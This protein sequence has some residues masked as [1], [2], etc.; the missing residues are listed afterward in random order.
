MRAVARLAAVFV[1]T[2]LLF[3]SI[4]FAQATISGLVRDTSGA[5]LPGVTV[6]AASPVLIEKVRTAVTDGNGRYQ[7][8][9]LRPG[10]YSVTVSLAGFNTVKRD[11]L[12]VT[13]SSIVTVDVELR[14]GSLEE[15][16]TVTGESPVVDTQSLTTQRVINADT[17]DALPS[18]RNYFGVARMVPGT[19][20]GGNDVGGSLIQDVGQGVTV[21]GSRQVDQRITINGI[22]TMTLQAGGGIGG[23][24]PDM[25]SAA[26]VTVDTSALG[27]DLPTGGLRVNFVPKDGGN[28]FSNSA[29]FSFTNESLQGDNFSDELRAQG[30]TT[31]NKILHAVD[32]NESFGGPMKRDKVWFWASFRVNDV[33][34]EAPV[35]VNKNAF[36]PNAWL[37]DPD[38]AQAGVNRGE[39]YNNSVRVTWQANAKNKIAGT[40]K[41]D[42][43]CNCP[44]Q[45]SATLAPEAARDRRFPRLRQE[46]A[47]WT[48]PVTNKLLF[49][50]VGMHLYERWG[51][52]HLRSS[53]GSITEEQEAIQPQMISVTEQSS[54]LVY[55]GRGP[56]Y[57]NTAVPSLSLRAAAAYVTGSHAFKVGWNH[58]SGYLDE[59]L[60]MLND[61][62]TY[63]FNTVGGVTTPNLVTLRGNYHA[64]TNLDGDMGLY[65]QDRW[66]M[67]RLTVAGAIRFDWFRTSFPDQTLGP[68]PMAP[69]R[70][71]TFP[72]ADNINWKDLTYRSGLSYDLFGTGKTAV[73]FSFNKYLLG[74]TLNALGRDP[75]P[76]IVAGNVQPTRAW[77]DLM[78]PV[79]DPRRGNFV[80]DCDLTTR[81][82]G[83]NGE[84]GAL[85]N[86][87]FGSAVPTEQF[88]PDL[89]S[90]FNHR[91]TNWET[92]VSV[93]HELMPRVG[94]DVGYFR[95]SW[96]NFRV[97]DNTLL[98]P[99]D[100][101][102]Y[103][104]VNP[105]DPRLGEDS[106]ATVRG[107]VD[108][109]PSK[110]GQV[111]NYNTLSTK[112]G[113]QSE[114]WQGVDVT[115]N[116]R[117]Q[118]GL[119]LQGGFS[120]GS[121]HEN[122]C[123][124]LTALPEMRNLA[125]VGNA[126]RPAFQRALQHCDRQSPY[127]T[128]AKLFG[129]YLVPKLDVQVSG[130][131]RSV[132][133]QIQG[134]GVNENFANVLLVATTPFLASNSNLGRP[135]SGNAPNSTVEILA[136][137]EHYLDRRNELDFR[138]GKL[139]R[140]NR[141]RLVLS[142]DFFNAL[143]SDAVVNVNQASTPAG[144]PGNWSLA[145]FWRPTE[146]LNAR[147]T[148][149]T[150]TYD[151]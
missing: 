51:D 3:P 80:P 34:N 149:F 42:A 89:I 92:S 91:Q 128:Q 96:A 67:S 78:F 137:L 146:I 99:S 86:L 145:S 115:V 104:I 148:K 139:V 68:V 53:T 21:H 35:F 60:Y 95:R 1:W 140:M 138:V 129:V 144:G 116:A 74:Q 120:T 122:D 54:G 33:A 31:P 19:L 44:S 109:I 46:H 37:Y 6:E 111:R 4:A 8:V 29:I 101:T 114:V 110:F 14:V 77:N 17:I 117:L 82:P 36:N 25:G 73:K 118:N 27:A 62:R 85:S 98:S 143:N 57:N 100:F 90:G 10:T 102:T 65:A 49:E 79:G 50:A 7:L 18:A 2:A 113:D 135:L 93:V 59:S 94:L 55:R 81:T 20:G 12:A 130:T 133:G 56:F 71:L 15:T 16:I 38:T 112:I 103:D 30:L 97:T 63:R 106:G 5:V 84:C 87:A 26:E 61:G 13:G 32:L 105:V 151:F 127:L 76:A 69:D 70:N 64:R 125:A 131:F 83:A 11:G 66:T 52:M 108:V 58:T 24:T 22:N 39:Q 88:D 134:N 107:F 43:W 126:A 119:N 136:P 72:E 47:E 48:S 123:D 150:V 41:A 141:H 23:Q 124:I 45:M 121:T 40:Y 147:V 28:T 9:D 75:N 132:P 142:V